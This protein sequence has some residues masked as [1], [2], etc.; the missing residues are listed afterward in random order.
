[1]SLY[2]ST[3]MIGYHVIIGDTISQV[4]E[5]IFGGKHNQTKLKAAVNLKQRDTSLDATELS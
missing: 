3:A 4:C 1:M 5:R 2:L